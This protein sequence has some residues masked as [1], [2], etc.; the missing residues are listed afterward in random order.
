MKSVYFLLVVVLFVPK[1]CV[2]NNKLLVV[3]FETCVL[4]LHSFTATLFLN[5]CSECH[6][7]LKAETLKSSLKVNKN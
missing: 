3:A 5:T 7:Y 2:R 1:V 6:I 4:V